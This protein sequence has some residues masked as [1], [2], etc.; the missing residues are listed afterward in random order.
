MR[1]AVLGNQPNWSLTEIERVAVGRHEV[2]FVEWKRLLAILGAEEFAGAP[3]IAVDAMIVRS[4]PAGSLEQVV[5]QMD[6]LA[7][8]AQGGCR[9]INAP[10]SLEISIDKFLTLALLR[11]NGLPVPETRVC[12]RCE[13]AM[14]AFADMGGDTVVKP[15]FGGEGRGIIRVSDPELALRA[16]R[17]IVNVGGIVYQQRFIAHAGFDTR[18]FVIGDD[19]FAMR[20]FGN[21]DWRTNA[22]RGAECAAWQPTASERDLALRSARA[23]QAVIAGVDLLYDDGG[24]PYVLEV[25][26]IPGWSNLARVTGVDIAARILQLIEAADLQESIGREVPDPRVC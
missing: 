23:T 3:Q 22:S 8:I 15:V 25:N 14:D 6:L 24:N 18:L 12:Q 4:M 7:R 13:D 16:F 21:D 10:R 9:I 20:R 1:I 19:V 17:A 26:G 11:E 5:F 2:C